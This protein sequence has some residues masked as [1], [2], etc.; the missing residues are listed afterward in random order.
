MA[1]NWRSS[2][3]TSLYTGSNAQ[4]AANPIYTASYG[5][6][7]ASLQYTVNHH[8][9]VYIDGSNILGTKQ[10]FYYGVPTLPQGAT[11]DDR[12]VMVGANVKF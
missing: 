2:F 12:I 3:Y 10:T 11:I 7:D 9:Q 8:V 4:L 1:Y 6:L 5:W